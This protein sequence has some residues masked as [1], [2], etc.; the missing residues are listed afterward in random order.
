MSLL[1]FFNR[2]KTRVLHLHLLRKISRCLLNE[3]LQQKSFE[4]GIHLIDAE[5]MARLNETFL[6]HQGS[7]DV[8]TF[9]YIEEGRAGSPPSSVRS[10]KNPLPPTAPLQGEIFISIDDAITHARQFR[11]TWQSELVRYLV[12]GILHLQGFDDLK[13]ALR[14]TMKRE[15]NR[16][17]KELSRRFDLGKLER[18]KPTR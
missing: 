3:L 9:N 4:L 2:Q 1:R 5:E 14:R 16:L 12:H 11:T 17:V 13:P 18:T 8:I 7:T 10:G 6:Q 15:E